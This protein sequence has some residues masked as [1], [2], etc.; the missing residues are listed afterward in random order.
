VVGV[1]ARIKKS[2]GKIT[3][4]RIGV[5][6]MGPRGFRATAAEQA[7]E[8]GADVAAAV[9]TIGV[10]EEANSDLYADAD[11]RRHLARVY[12][13]RAIAVEISRAS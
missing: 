10:N 5:T 9:A 11:Y 7:L 1:A 2:G 12:A 4:A 3:M 13:S 6:G 8:S